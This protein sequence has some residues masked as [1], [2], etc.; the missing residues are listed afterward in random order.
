MEAHH[1]SG[2]IHAY[3]K[4]KQGLRMETDPAHALPGHRQLPQR[5]HRL[6]EG[7]YGGVVDKFPMGSLV[8]RSLT[9]KA[10]QCHV[11]RYM[12][13]LLQRFQ[14]GEIDPTFVI[15][16]RRSLAEAPRGF[17]TFRNKQDE[18]VKVVLTP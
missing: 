3:D 1:G 8:N 7:V 5:R 18:C 12:R 14:K 4:F 9:V 11:H 16:H 17:D 10:G 6:G 13:P 15:T 2:A